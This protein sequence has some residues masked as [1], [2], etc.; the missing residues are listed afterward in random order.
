M[1]KNKRHWSSAQVILR[2]FGALI[3]AGTML[4]MLPVSSR[5]GQWTSFHHAGRWQAGCAY[6]RTSAEL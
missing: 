6:G 5:S 1:L 3:L 4:L 2:G